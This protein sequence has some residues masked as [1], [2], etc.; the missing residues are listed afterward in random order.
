M[1]YNRTLLIGNYCRLITLRLAAICAFKSAILCINVRV[2]EQFS[3][4]PGSFNRS[5]TSVMK[6]KM[7]QT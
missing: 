6:N 3:N 2:P 4:F 1:L 7:K 5:V